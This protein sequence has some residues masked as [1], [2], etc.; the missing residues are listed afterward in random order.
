MRPMNQVLFSTPSHQPIPM[1]TRGLRRYAASALMAGLLAVWAA[2]CSKNAGNASAGG[3]PPAFPVQVQ[4]TP[5]VKIP[6][7]TEYL[8]ILKS[9]RSANINPDVEGQVTK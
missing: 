7:A 4:V 6:E 9:R 2:G 3:P 5:S 1:K 8:S